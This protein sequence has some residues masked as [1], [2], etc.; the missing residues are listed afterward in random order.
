MVRMCYEYN[1]NLAELN[2]PPSGVRKAEEE[3]CVEESMS[4]HIRTYVCIP[5]PSLP[6]AWT[7][8]DGMI[9]VVQ[10]SKNITHA[11]ITVHT[12]VSPR[13][14]FRPPS[15]CMQH[16]LNLIQWYNVP[17]VHTGGGGET[18]DIPLQSDFSPP[19]IK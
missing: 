10:M 1:V 8:I 9:E 19:R 17:G 12:G 18:W 14:H 15:I 2:Y 3:V 13:T 5:L 6:M 11:L 7:V 4:L 16:V